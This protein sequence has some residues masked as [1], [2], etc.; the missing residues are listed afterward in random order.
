MKLQTML[1]KNWVCSVRSH[2]SSPIRKLKTRICISM[3]VSERFRSN[4]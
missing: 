3:R 1:W 2:Y 4:K